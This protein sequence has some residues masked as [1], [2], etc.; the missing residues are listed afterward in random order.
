[1]NFNINLLFL[2]SSN[3]LSIKLSNYSNYLF[4]NILKLL[5]FFF[6]SFHRSLTLSILFRLDSF[7]SNYSDNK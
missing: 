4:E 1:M 3:F 7:C 5:I 2:Y 6:T